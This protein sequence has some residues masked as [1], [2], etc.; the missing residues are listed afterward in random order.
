MRMMVSLH[1]TM[2]SMYRALRVDGYRTRGLLTV[3]AFQKLF[4]GSRQHHILRGSYTLHA[5]RAIKLNERI[6]FR[7]IVTWLSSEYYLPILHF[8]WCSHHLGMASHLRLCLLNHSF[9]LGR[10]F[11]VSYSISWDRLAWRY[12]HKSYGMSVLVR[13]APHSDIIS[14]RVV[15]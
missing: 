15:S 7:Y 8:N 11:G 1:L 3:V 9:K 5:M 6:F 10:S 14:A 13:T 2:C 12:L 4:V